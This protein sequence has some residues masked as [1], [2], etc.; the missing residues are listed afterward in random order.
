MPPI[1]VG[2]VRYSVLK[3]SED[4]GNLSFLLRSEAGELFGVYRR[5]A[6]EAL[7]AAPLKLI[8][9]VDNPFKGM[10]FFEIAGGGL[11]VRS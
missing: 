11:E 9:S 2:G 10:D 5:N 4:R 7:S 8:F 6:Q 3:L 1:V